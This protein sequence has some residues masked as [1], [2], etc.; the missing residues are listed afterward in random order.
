[1][2]KYFLIILVSCIGMGCFNSCYTEDIVD[3][4]FTFTGELIGDYISNRPELFSEFG[5]I[6]DT[7]RVMGLLKAHGLYTCF[8]PTNDA[9]KAYYK[10]QGRTRRS[11]F[12]VAELKKICYNHII[13]GDT[14][15]TLAFSE[16]ALSTMNMNAR[17]ISV[18]YRDTTSTIFMNGTAPII[19][20]DVRLHNGIV[21]VL[22]QALEPTEDRVSMAIAADSKF[23]LFTEAMMLTGYKSMI[24]EAEVEDEDYDPDDYT[25]TG[26]THTVVEELPLYRKFGYTILAESDETLS[27]NGIN[28]IEQLYEYA[29]GQY[30]WMD[31]NPTWSKYYK[32][33]SSYSDKYTDKRNYLNRYIAYHLIDRTLL[34]SRF[35]KDFDTPHM[36][37]TYDLYEYI[38]TLLDNTLIEVKLDRGFKDGQ[39]AF[40]LFNCLSM[41]DS[42]TGLDTEDPNTGIRLTD[43]IDKP[44]G[45]S[46]NGYYHEITAPL[47]YSQD[48]ERFL[49][50][51]RLR[52]EAS[53]N[54][55]EVATNNMRGNNPEATPS[56]PGKTHAYQIPKGYF[57]NMTCTDGTRFTYIGAATCYEDFEGDEIYCRQQYDFTIK[58]MPIPAGK[59]EVRMGY[60]PTAWRG[61]A[62]LY[63]DSI[64][65]GIPVNF[66]LLADD[67]AIGHEVPGT[68]PDD[69]Y[70]YENDKMM[71]N[72]GYMKGPDTWYAPNK[73]YSYN[74]ANA[75]DSKFNLR[76]IMG[77]Y[78]F[79]EAKPHYV[80][81]VFLGIGNDMSGGDSQFM[82]D[83]LEFCP[84]ELIL[85]ENI[86]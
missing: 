77:T 38:P 27:K 62:Q 22:G 67:P 35:I 46:I 84:I 72:R 18:S 42:E 23:T 65:T 29:K 83:Y 4:Y 68:N 6:L 54:F 71:R 75:R 47:V 34:S 76:Y 13:K 59:Y 12:S 3:N 15:E 48:F 25:P 17:Y 32:G 2:K 16:G 19:E 53:A 26:F 61:I 11:D 70:G 1:M 58:T 31:N 50:S 21:H 69:P 37:E 57:D 66:S 41:T 5:A 80:T 14:I 28:N 82:L 20:K 55:K 51:K 7:T 40:G 56:V 85:T 74:A 9:M 63:W 39:A 44:D 49:S 8:L 73:M 10:N 36:F 79:K 78:E 81:V 64:P 86:H 43:Y 45:G 24:D 52:I 30:E 33:S 60:Q